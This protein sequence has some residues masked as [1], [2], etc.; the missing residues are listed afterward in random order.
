M[1]Q[2][3]E[4]DGRI[5]FKY[6]TGWKELLE[7]DRFKKELGWEAKTNF[8]DLIKEMMRSDLEEAEKQKFLNSKSFN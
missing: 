7:S 2:E 8:K 1:N 6:D 5:V 4:I 3:Q